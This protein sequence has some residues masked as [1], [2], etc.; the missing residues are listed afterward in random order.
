MNG[1][2]CVRNIAPA[3]EIHALHIVANCALDGIRG[4]WVL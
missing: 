3:G 2:D 1:I 4:V